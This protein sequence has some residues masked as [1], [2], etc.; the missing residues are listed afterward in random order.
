MVGRDLGALAE[1]STVHGHAPWLP[2][3]A[4][5]A[6]HLGNGL[7]AGLGKATWFELAPADRRAFCHRCE[8]RPLSA[9]GARLGQLD[10]GIYQCGNCMAGGHLANVGDKRSSGIQ[11]LK[12]Y[13]TKFFRRPIRS[14]RLPVAD[15]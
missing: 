4:I 12:N 6:A 3:L 1:Q 8:Q 9:N 7:G 14:C 10:A 13:L 2:A 11:G 5:F 15:S